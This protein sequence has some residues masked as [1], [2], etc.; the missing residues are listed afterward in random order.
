MIPFLVCLWSAGCA[1][2]ILWHINTKILMLLKEIREIWKQ[3]KKQ[4]E[5]NLVISEQIDD[6]MKRQLRDLTEEVDINRQIGVLLKGRID[7]LEQLKIHQM[8]I[9]QIQQILVDNKLAK[10]EIK[11]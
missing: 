7:T 10:R 3:F 1:L 6:L 9:G 2:G 11:Q 4:S 5:T 8:Y